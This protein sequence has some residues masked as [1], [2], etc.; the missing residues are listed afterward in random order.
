M[1]ALT[2]QELKDRLRVDFTDDMTDRDL[3]N[4]LLEAD[5]YAR[6]ALGEN[7]PEDDP[8]V[9]AIQKDYIHLSVDASFIS[10]K[11]RAAIEKR[12]K[13]L[14]E[15]VRLEMRSGGEGS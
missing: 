6:G 4:Y 3:S 14:S 7:Y 11:E 13:T 1:S 9:K 2:M 10:E 5:M 8:R 12:I 15:Q